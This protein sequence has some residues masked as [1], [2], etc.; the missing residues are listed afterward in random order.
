VVANRTTPSLAG[1][2][3]RQADRSIFNNP[4]GLILMLVYSFVPRTRHA[5][6]VSGRSD[7]AEPAR[8]SAAGD[9]D[10]LQNTNGASRPRSKS[11]LRPDQRA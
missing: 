1:A 8:Q 4:S 7:K 10:T 2:A 3:E 6:F 9:N 5:T 11:S